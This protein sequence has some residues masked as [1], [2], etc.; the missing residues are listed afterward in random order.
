MPESV[1]ESRIVPQTETA[2]AELIANAA[3]R[4]RPGGSCSRLGID[5]PV[6][7]DVEHLAELVTA[8]LRARA[9]PVARVRAEH[10]LRGR[11]LRLEFGRDDPDAF[12]DGW[13]DWAALRREVLDPLGP[14]G[15]GQWLPRLRDPV[16]D[17]PFRD[18]RQVAAAGTV[19][20]V[21]GRFLGRWGL[22]GTLDVLVLLDV[23]PPARQ[24]RLP[25]DEHARVLPAWQRYLDECDPAARA[26][27]VVRYDHPDR[28]AT[29]EPAG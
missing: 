29:L 2:L 20:V 8:S 15:S 16:T 28:P 6:H 5:G 1:P 27:L 11:S 4:A 14:D 13:Y 9:V 17:R 22:F 3:A 25:P 21:S 10:Y 19:A 24:R 23:T 26:D 18:P 7:D 12:F